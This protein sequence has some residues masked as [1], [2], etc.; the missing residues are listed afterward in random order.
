MM[1]SR[2]TGT[3]FR[4]LERLDISPSGGIN[5]LIGENAQGKTSAL[6][7]VYLLSVGRALRGSRDTECILEGVDSCHV[8]AV[9]EPT[10]T[11]LGMELCHGRRKRGLL[12]SLPLPRASDL[13]GRMP[14]VC[15][16][17]GDLGIVTRDPAVRRLFLDT[18]L[19]QIHA[20]YLRNLTVYKRALEHRNALLKTAQDSLVGDDAFEP[21]EQQSWPVARTWT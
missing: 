6:E 4:N 9:V 2:L 18:E 10:G 20:S 14:S 13:L 11:E 16:W 3:N 12:N 5:L 17:S 8:S 1:V 21:G 7:A 19:C 15:F